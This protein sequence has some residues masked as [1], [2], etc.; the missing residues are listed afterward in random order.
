MA[1]VRTVRIVLGSLAGVV[2]LLQAVS[3][4][5]YLGRQARVDTQLL[6]A[7]A[8]PV[9]ASTDVGDI[10]VRVAAAGERPRL[11]QRLRWAFWSPS[12]SFHSAEGRVEARSN[13]PLIALMCKADVELVVASG[14]P[15]R[16]HTS[17][18]DVRVEPTSA[19]VTAV[20]AFGDVVVHGGGEGADL[21]AETSTGDVRVIASAGAH[22]IRA[23]SA[24]GDVRVDVAPGETFAVD[25]GTDVGDTRI[26]V[27]SDPASGRSLVA[28]TSTGD[29]AVVAGD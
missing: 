13:C 28:R 11:E 21:F 22:S 29:V 5:G 1:P 8:G 15:V 17:V 14:S 16:V 27:A 20:T 18:G 9:E 25:A 26:D 24:T 2:V 19:D 6:P 12:S 10:T 3:V 4:A 23:V 7:T